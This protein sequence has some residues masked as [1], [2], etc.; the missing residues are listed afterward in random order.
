MVCP[1]GSAQLRYF[2]QKEFFSALSLNSIQLFS[3]AKHNLRNVYN[4][5]LIIKKILMAGKNTPVFGILSFSSQ[6]GERS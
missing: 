4:K 5:Q 3:L 6:G 2:L 1:R